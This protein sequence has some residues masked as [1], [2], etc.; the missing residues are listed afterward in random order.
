MLLKAAFKNE[1]EGVK[2]ISEGQLL[3]VL[4]TI[5]KHCLWFP[6]L[7]TLDYTVLLYFAF[8]LF[9]WL[10]QRNRWLIINP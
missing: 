9:P 5:K 4:Q 1:G 10:S 7:S 2:K 8:I 6:S 3:E